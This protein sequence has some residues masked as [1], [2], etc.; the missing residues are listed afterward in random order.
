MKNFEKHSRGKESVILIIKQVHYNEQIYTKENL[1]IIFLHAFILIAH[2]SSL[3][4]QIQKLLQHLIQESMPSFF[5][6]TFFCIPA[7]PFYS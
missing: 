7:V 3:L 5:F 2:V 1:N 4:A 6:P